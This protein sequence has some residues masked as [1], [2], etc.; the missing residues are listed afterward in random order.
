ME[1]DRPDVVDAEG[2][3]V[4][5]GEEYYVLQVVACSGNGGGLALKMRVIVKANYGDGY[6]MYFCPCNCRLV[7][8]KLGIY[9]DDDEN[10]WLVIN[11][12][13]EPTLIDSSSIKFCI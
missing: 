8:T 10:R 2:H 4:V 3:P 12:S 7:C 13:V 6:V 9:V 5:V 1:T 11:N